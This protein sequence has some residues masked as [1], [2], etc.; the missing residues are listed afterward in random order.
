VTRGSVGF[1]NKRRSRRTVAAL[2]ATTL[3]G[4][5]RARARSELGEVFIGQEL[6]KQRRPSVV[7]T[8]TAAWAPRRWTTCGGAPAS[9][10]WRCARA[11]VLGGRVSPA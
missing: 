9:G 3:A 7:P 4:Y 1:G 2:M 8:G 6:H 11:R 10:R 5:S